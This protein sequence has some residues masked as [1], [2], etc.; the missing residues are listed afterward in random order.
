MPSSRRVF[1]KHSGILML[2]TLLTGKSV[3]AIATRLAEYFAAE[4]FNKIFAKVIGNLPV[5]D[6]GNIKLILPDIAED[7]AVVPVSITSELDG[8]ETI[9][10]FADKNPTP[11]LAEFQLSPVL[12]AQITG[13]VKLAASCNVILLARRNGEW[14]R[15]ARWVNVMRGGCG[16]G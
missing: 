9:F 2:G 16:T 5:S 13:R 3:D 12:L 7:G 6:T 4:D 15:T 11:L 10:L 8:I 1:L 14:L